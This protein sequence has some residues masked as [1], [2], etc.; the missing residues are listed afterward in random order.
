VYWLLHNKNPFFIINS[1]FLC[2]LE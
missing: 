1:Q 2:S